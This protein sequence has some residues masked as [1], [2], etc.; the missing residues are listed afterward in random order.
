MKKSFFN[1]FTKNISS[2]KNFK[3]TKPKGILEII[4]QK[5]ENN[6]NI[7]NLEKIFQDFDKNVIKEITEMHYINLQINLKNQNKMELMKILSFPLYFKF[8]EEIENKKNFKKEKKEKNLKNENFENLGNF[9][10]KEFNFI[11][12]SQLDSSKILKINHYEKIDDNNEI[13][14]W[15]QVILEIMTRDEKNNYNKQFITLERRENELENEDWK[16]CCIE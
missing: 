8:E 2:Y 10:N 12:N 16:I 3:Y 5:R 9:D 13:E 11:L 15:Y 7:K 14:N 4:K 6:K 1:S